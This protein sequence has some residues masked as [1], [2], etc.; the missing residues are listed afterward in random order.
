MPWLGSPTSAVSARGSSTRVSAGPTKPPTSDAAARMT[1]AR[2]KPKGSRVTGVAAT[3]SLVPNAPH[4][5]RNVYATVSADP[6]T[7]APVSR[8]AG[9]GGMPVWSPPGCSR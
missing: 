8:N 9:S 3:P 2:P 5:K 7:S 1:G 6:A 4:R